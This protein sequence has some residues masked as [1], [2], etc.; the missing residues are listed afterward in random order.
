MKAAGTMINLANSTPSRML[1]FYKEL[2]DN[3]V[4]AEIAK[5]LFGSQKV[6]KSQQT[7]VQALSVAIHPLTGNTLSFPWH[8]ATS[9]SAAIKEYVETSGVVETL[10]HSV[11]SALSEYT[12]IEKL[13]DIYSYEEPS[14]EHEKPS[15]TT[16]KSSTKLSCLRIILQMLRSNKELS[17][18]QAQAGLVLGIANDAISNPANDS[19]L[20]ATGLLLIAA[21]A[22][23]FASIKE[24]HY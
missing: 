20:I 4:M 21:M 19:V 15:N 24:R 22:K 8:S 23:Q 12:W 18:I 14:D 17:Q 11:F 2:G 16:N 3:K 10:K 7:A 1:P 6:G 13:K 9:E 5:E